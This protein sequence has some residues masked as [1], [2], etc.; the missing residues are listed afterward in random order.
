MLGDAI[1]L[2]NV[3]PFDNK[4][5]ARY[6]TGKNVK[7]DYGV[8]NFTDY[9]EGSSSVKDLPTL[10][11]LI[12]TSF[13]NINPNE[14]NYDNS[15]ARIIPNLK[16]PRNL[17]NSYFRYIRTMHFMQATLWQPPLRRMS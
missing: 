9:F 13:T 2:S 16:Q 10:F 5:I 17:Q 15:K 1:S 8:G 6:L 4:T 12:Y 11:E 3:G 7:L 14:E